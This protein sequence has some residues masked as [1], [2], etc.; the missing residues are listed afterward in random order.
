MW[1]RQH[2]WCLRDS[3]RQLARRPFGTAL[4]IVVMGLALALPLAFY[5]FLVNVQHLAT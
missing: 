1:R 2:A 4:T 3:L 5:H